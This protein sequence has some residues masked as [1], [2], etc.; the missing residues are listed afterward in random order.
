MLPNGAAEKNL[1]SLFEGFKATVSIIQ[2]RLLLDNVNLSPQ[3]IVIKEKYVQLP[4]I[5]TG[6]VNKIL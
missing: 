6:F 1:P 3:R 4:D 5:N 2:Q